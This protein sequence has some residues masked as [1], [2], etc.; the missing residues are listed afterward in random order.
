MIAFQINIFTKL[1]TSLESKLLNI[2]NVFLIAEGA[3][4]GLFCFGKKV[5]EK[6]FR[7][8]LLKALSSIS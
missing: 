6:W 4:L 8:F 1:C 3:L 5:K 2:Q 7:L